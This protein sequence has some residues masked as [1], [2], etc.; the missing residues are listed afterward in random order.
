MCRIFKTKTS[1]LLECSCFYKNLTATG[2]RNNKK[3]CTLV[4]FLLMPVHIFSFGCIFFRFDWENMKSIDTAECIFSFR[5]YF[6]PTIPC[7][8]KTRDRNRK[9]QS[10]QGQMTRNSNLPIPYLSQNKRICTF[11]SCA[12]A[13]HT[14]SFSL[15]SSF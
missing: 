3:T 1:T 13:K 11:Q 15:W 14:F 9:S 10:S 4:S 8:V 5:K 2:P 12:S 6:I 7:F